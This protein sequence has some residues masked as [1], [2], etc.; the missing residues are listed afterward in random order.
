MSTVDPYAAARAA[1]TEMFGVVQS[2]D[3]TCCLAHV[4]R[5]LGMATRSYEC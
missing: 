5:F 4:L 2:D 3:Q 1:V